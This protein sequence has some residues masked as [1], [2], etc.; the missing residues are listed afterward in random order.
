MA[1]HCRVCDASLQ[2]HQQI[3]VRGVPTELFA[4][5]RCGLYEFPE[6][7]WLDEAYKDPIADIDVGLAARCRIVSSIVETVVRAQRVQ[8]G[9]LLDFGGGYG[10]LT[11]F[12]RD[13]GLEMLHHDPMAANLFAQGFE[14]LPGDD[15]ALCTMSEVLEHLGDPRSVFDQLRHIDLLLTTTEIVP[16]GM[17]DLEPWPYL[18]PDLGQHITFYGRRSLQRLA[19]DFGYRLASDGFGVH[20]FYRGRLSRVARTVLRRHRL[21]PVTAVALRRLQHG[22]S[23]QVEDAVTALTQARNIASP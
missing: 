8:R 9:K 20:L 19:D 5:G 13:A 15:Y 1:H 10:L 4:C 6:P 3:A 16:P 21:A 2:P 11:R 14:G 18:I 22:R 23:L 17:T 12:V 7:T